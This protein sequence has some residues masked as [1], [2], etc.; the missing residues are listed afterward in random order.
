[1][2]GAHVCDER[3]AQ[4]SLG[5][6]V[7]FGREL[8]EPARFG[9]RG[10]TQLAG[11]DHAI[12]I[13]HRRSGLWI[14][15]A[16]EQRGF[17]VAV[18]TQSFVREL[19]REH[20]KGKPDRDL[21]QADLELAR[22]TD[23]DIAGQEQQR[24][25]CHRVTRAG[26]HHRLRMLIEL[27]HDLGAGRHEVGRGFGALHHDLEVEPSAEAPLA[28]REHDGLRFLACAVESPAQ[29][30][31]HG[32]VQ[33]VR[34]AII[35]RDDRDI[36][37]LFEGEHFGHGGL[38]TLISR[39]WQ[40]VVEFFATTPKNGRRGWVG[41]CEDGAV[42]REAHRRSGHPL[43]GGNG[44]FMS[45]V[46]ALVCALLTIGVACSD[47]A[48][49][50]APPQATTQINGL[51]AG[52]G[53]AQA[54]L[55]SQDRG[56]WAG[57]VQA[58]PEPADPAE[59]AEYEATE[60]DEEAPPAARHA[61]MRAPMRD[62][63]I[64]RIEEGSPGRAGRGMRR[65]RPNMSLAS[66][67]MR[68]GNID[69]L[70]NQGLGGPQGR[71]AA[72]TETARP[73]QQPATPRAQVPPQNRGVL[74][75][76]ALP[77]NGVLASNFVGGSGVRA[78]LDD[79]LDR[80][81]MVGGELVRLEAFQDRQRLPYAVPAREG[82]AMYAELERTRLTEDTDRVHMQIAL[83][84]RQGEAPRRPH[85]DVRLVLDRS[86]S[87]RGEKWNQAIA[88]AHALID[89][90]E[91]SDRF[92]LITYSDDA[93]LDHAPRNVGNGQVAHSNLNRLVPG[94]GTNISAA[95]ELAD[96][97][98]PRARSNQTVGL[99]ILI[100]D[101]RATM[102]M[103]NAQELGAISR[104]SF[105][106][107]GVLTTAIGL[108]TDF[109]EST[110]LSIAREGSGSYHFVRRAADIGDILQDELDERVQAVAQGLRVRVELGDG[111]VARRVYGSRLLSEQ[112]HAAVRATEVAVD[113]RIAR[114]LGI[115][116][117]RQREEDRGLRI[118][119]PTFR[120]GDQH[121]ILMELEVP[122]GTGNTSI[123]KV[124]LDYKD[125]IRRQNG[126]IVR[127]VTADRVDDLA[128]AQASVNRPVK[129]TVLAFQG[130]E[131]L[132]TAAEA[133]QRGDAPSAHRI[134]SERR[135]LLQA[136]SQ[137]WRDPS[138]GADAVL[139]SR[140]ERVVDHAWQDWDSGAQNTL[141]MAMNYFGD[142]RM[143]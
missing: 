59:Y 8:A 68:V 74:D 25:T 45:R 44:G 40:A 112:E 5:A 110:M 120:R 97:H 57:E 86:G 69:D 116:R 88:A 122:R 131:A 20:R 54:D 133:L 104:R 46:R 31:E 37:F 49:E 78:R 109:D 79:L 27:D 71:R 48:D 11:C 10:S 60:A 92:G 118:H 141:V 34:L 99:T 127:E 22:R 143:R 70:L 65:M 137:H 29:R 6:R 94:G 58:V 113:N 28:T 42:R 132:Q 128:T 106:R 62:Q 123:A 105:D 73:T 13:A 33:G 77:Q 56:D 117:T 87:M 61:T 7:G 81:V 100:S 50:A 138:L 30:G 66:G 129:R 84:G 103:L 23:A 4:A 26:G 36:A 12:E 21:V 3:R 125:L 24:S 124:T 16:R 41:S 43:C 14:E 98:A 142:Q 90:L 115:A 107:A 85:M 47:Q 72:Q 53:G 91:P 75:T 80:G 19:R 52:G 67:G 102:G 55:R 64:G 134:L 96:E 76:Q 114:E 39:G 51:P 18:A 136:A 38:D 130:G 82:M 1:M 32:R 140:Y 93:R 135:E 101:G 119:L 17:D 108:G 95:L 63:S 121:A 89:A 83:M 126:R 139:L 2:R 15:H 111:V 9:D 35:H